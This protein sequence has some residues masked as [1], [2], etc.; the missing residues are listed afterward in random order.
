MPD[1]SNNSDST[2]VRDG[3]PTMVN[4]AGKQPNQRSA[5]MGT[6][7][8]ALVHPDGRALARR[9]YDLLAEAGCTTVVL[10]LRHDQALPPG[11][12]DLENVVIARDP[13]GAREGPLAGMIGDF[14]VAVNDEF[15]PWDHPLND[16]DRI[17]LLPPMSG[18]G[19]LRI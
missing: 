16:G 1:E 19:G 2:H 5:R 4:V 18:G 15:V 8:A 10:S 14:R 12:S 6:D 9:T 13:E 11:F 7:K 17:A 3:L